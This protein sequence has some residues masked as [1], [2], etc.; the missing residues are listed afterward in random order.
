MHGRPRAS[1]AIFQRPHTHKVPALTVYSQGCP[2]PSLS[3][4]SASTSSVKVSKAT[5]LCR[6]SSWNLRSWREHCVIDDC[7]ARAWRERRWKFNGSRRHDENLGQRNSPLATT[8]PLTSH[9]TPYSTYDLTDQVICHAYSIEVFWIIFSLLDLSCNV[10]ES[11]V[12]TGP[13][14]KS[15]CNRLF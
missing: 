3:M 5:L 1:F 7:T 10:S 14:P 8:S 13:S 12:G 4:L 15:L 2:V 11:A 6:F 9:Y